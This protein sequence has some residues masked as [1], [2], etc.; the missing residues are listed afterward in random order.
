MKEMG[1][2]SMRR[3]SVGTLSF[4]LLFLAEIATYVA[5]IDEWGWG[6]AL[7][8]GVGSL[9]LGFLVLSRLGQDMGRVFSNAGGNIVQLSFGGLFSGGLSIAGAILLIL[10]G[11]LTDFL[12]LLLVIA[13][14]GLRFLPDRFSPAS[15]P[16]RDMGGGVTDLRPEEWSSNRNTPS[17]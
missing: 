9:A 15:S 17:Q 4:L 5:V 3:F 7:G 16:V 13:S 11:F 1:Q 6:T 8:I 14:F 10:P 2:N 12:G